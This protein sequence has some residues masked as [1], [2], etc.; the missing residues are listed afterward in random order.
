MSLRHVRRI[1]VTAPGS[2]GAALVGIVSSHDVWRACP[3]SLH[4]LSAEAWPADEDASVGAVMTS[5]VVTTTP[6]TPI[7]AAASLMRKRKIG[8]LPVVRGERLVGIVTESDLLDV[9]LELAGAG[10]RGLRVSL[11]L[12]EGDDVVH[13]LLAVGERHGMRLASVLTFHH[14]DPE[15]GGVR[16]YGVARLVGRESEALIDEIR[17]TCRRVRR[18]VRAEGEARAH[19][20]VRL[21]PTRRVS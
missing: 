4:P 16:R 10:E 7:E 13:E 5:K 21:A 1:P 8:A 14:A 6:D 17:S 3:A 2:H 11:E 18:I 9:L 19:A 12:D 20:P 15:G